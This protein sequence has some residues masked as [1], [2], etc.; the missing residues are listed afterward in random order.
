MEENT[1]DDDVLIQCLKLKKGRER[2]DINI[3][4]QGYRCNSRLL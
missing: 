2:Q 3:Q 4:M 1:T